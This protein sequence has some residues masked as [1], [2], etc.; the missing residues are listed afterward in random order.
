[1]KKVSRVAPTKAK[2]G[3]KYDGTK[4]RYDLAPP[5]A[6][7]QLMAVMTFGAVK[8]GP[9]NWRDVDGAEARYLAAAQRHLMAFQAAR[10]GVRN[11]SR[12]DKE[13]G[14]S[15]LSHALTCLAFMVELEVGEMMTEDEIAAVVEKGLAAKAVKK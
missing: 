9:D 10:K 14:L 4:L 5:V 7:D 13:T 1:M 6:M 12:L 3:I 15:H 2:P 11:S 8:Y